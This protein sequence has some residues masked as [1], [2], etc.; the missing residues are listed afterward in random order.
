MKILSLIETK[1]KGSGCLDMTNG[2]YLIYGGVEKSKHA[3]TGVVVK[4]SQRMLAKKITD[5][6]KYQKDL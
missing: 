4:N 2:H 1:K 5:G 3:Q 6:I